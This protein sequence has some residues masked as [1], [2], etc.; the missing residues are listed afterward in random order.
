MVEALEAAFRFGHGRVT[1]Y[2]L[3][4]PTQAGEPLRFSADLHC[5]DCDIHYREPIPNLFSF[6]SPMGACETCRG[7]G[8]VIGIDWGLVM[9]DESKT[10]ASRGGQ[11]L[12]DRQLPGSVRK[13]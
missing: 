4:R 7:F 12:A 10:P 9:P 5:P 13:T 8:R 2:P 3:E 6:N 11:T 1:V